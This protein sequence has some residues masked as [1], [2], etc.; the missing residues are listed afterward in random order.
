MT[1]FEIRVSVT[2]SPHKALKG[3]R[4]VLG[5]T[6]QARTV[7]AVRPLFTPKVNYT[8]GAVAV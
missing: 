6:E 5:N 2:E 1:I 4:S 7:G 8:P 3:F